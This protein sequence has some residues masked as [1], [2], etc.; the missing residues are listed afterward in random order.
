MIWK[1]FNIEVFTC[2][3]KEELVLTLNCTWGTEAHKLSGEKSTDQPYFRVRNNSN[4][5]YCSIHGAVPSVWLLTW[6]PWVLEGLLAYFRSGFMNLHFILALFTFKLSF[7][8]FFV[9]VLEMWL[10]VVNLNFWL[11][12]LYLNCT[13]CL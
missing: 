10:Y 2:T 5:L 12:S 3:K 9:I 4:Y 8:S 6:R 11:F 1:S 13:R 7:L